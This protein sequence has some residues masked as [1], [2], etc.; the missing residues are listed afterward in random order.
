MLT[1]SIFNYEL[2]TL[3]STAK[4]RRAGYFELIPLFDP[5]IYGSMVKTIDFAALVFRVAIFFVAKI[6]PASAYGL[7]FPYNPLDL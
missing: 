7:M 1:N 2:A 3:L 5:A 4:S 6:L